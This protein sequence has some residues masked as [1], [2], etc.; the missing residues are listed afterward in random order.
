MQKN[1]PIY[2]TIYSTSIWIAICSAA[3]LWNGC[4]QQKPDLPVILHING[5]PIYMDELELLGRMAL[6]KANMVFDTEEGQ[7][8]YKEIASNLYD[9][10]IDLYVIKEAAKQ[11]IT[12]I[13]PAVVETEMENFVQNLKDQGGYEKFMMSLGLNEDRLRELIADMLAMNKLQESKLNEGK[14]EPTEEEIKNYY[15]QN[16]QMFRFPKRLRASHIFFEASE[17]ADPATHTRAQDR[18]KQ[19]LQLMNNDPA[20]NWVRLA[21]TY[22]EDPGNSPRGGDLG[23]ITR[24]SVLYPENFKEAAWKIPVGEMSD[25]LQT[26][27]GYHIIW[28]TD[29]EQSLEEASAEIKQQLIQQS[30]TEYFQTWKLG[31]RMAMDIQRY[32]DP[33]SF[34]VLDEPIKDQPVPILPFQGTP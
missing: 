30:M 16:N 27:L 15:Y 3:L 13:E 29:H 32:F 7:Q 21:Q 8:R 25:I 18:A 33:V 31:V 26:N 1:L 28:V 9:T 24:E 14:R 4:A 12:T 10:L 23:F 11:E 5:E 6:S 22:S 34:T 20:T 2:T 17:Q 19:M